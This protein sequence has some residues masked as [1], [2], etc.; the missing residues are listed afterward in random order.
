M[1]TGDPLYP[2]HHL[3]DPLPSGWHLRSFSP[4]TSGFINSFF[5][6]AIRTGNK[7]YHP[8]TLHLPTHSTNLSHGLSNPDHSGH[9]HTDSIQTKSFA[10]FTS[11]LFSSVCILSCFTY[12]PL[13]C[14]F[15][16]CLLFIPAV[17]ALI[18]YF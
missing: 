9:S 18:F 6:W 14:I 2:A 16:C 11:T 1:I 17:L 3:F 8:H 5:P 12:L 15:F 13:V 4:H 10:L 7:H